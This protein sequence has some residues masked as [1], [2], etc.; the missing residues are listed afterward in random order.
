M[1]EK[2]SGK[3]S[4][5]GSKRIIIKQLRTTALSLQKF[6]KVK[7]VFSLKSEDRN[8]IFRL[9]LFE[10]QNVFSSTINSDFLQLLK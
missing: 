1:V 4:T 10:T 3:K 2:P 8:H 7:N 9:I 5:K 6:H